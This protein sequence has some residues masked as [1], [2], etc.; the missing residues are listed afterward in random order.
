MVRKFLYGSAVDGSSVGLARFQFFFCD[1][2]VVLQWAHFR[3]HFCDVVL[4]SGSFS[5]II[6]AISIIL[7]FLVCGLEPLLVVVPLIF[8][9]LSLLYVQKDACKLA[10]V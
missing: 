4:R 2:D 9:A 1:C 6:F 5:I 7:R 8:K 3:F 10:S